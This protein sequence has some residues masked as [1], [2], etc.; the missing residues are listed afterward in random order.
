MNQFLE[1]GRLF[2]GLYEREF[3]ALILTLPRVY[4][5]IYVSQIMGL[6]AVPR[7]IRNVMVLVLT[8]FAAPIN[9]AH[10]GGFNGSILTYA[11]YFF[12]EAVIGVIMGYVFGWV[13]WAIQSAGALIDNQRGAAIASSIDPLHA[14]ET[15]PLGSLFAQAFLT[16][17][18]LSGAIL[19][20]VFVLFQSFV[21]WPAGQP[22]PGP[23][24]HLPVLLLSMADR[25]MRIIVIYAL[26]VIALMFLTEFALALVSRFT[27]QVQVFILSMPIKSALAM[28]ILIFYLSR[29]LPEANGDLLSAGLGLRELIDALLATPEAPA[30]QSIE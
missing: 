22:I 27:P 7:L 15:T 20:I 26:P 14:H 17:T 30:P 23:T 3:T 13:F 2:L 10:L 1:V 11:A 29:L 28:F 12:K 16:Y 18:F 25:G 5:F 9:L 6:Q 24:E 4:L 19:N 8:A 21:L